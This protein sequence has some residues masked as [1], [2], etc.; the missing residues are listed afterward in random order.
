MAKV[1]K[2]IKGLL[3]NADK[4]NGCRACEVI[5]SAFHAN[6]RYGSIN[7]ARSRIRVVRDPLKDIY[8][9]VQAGEYT[10]SECTGR[11]RYIVDG[12]EYTRKQ[13]FDLV[14]REAGLSQPVALLVRHIRIVVN[15][16][17]RTEP[18]VLKTAIWNER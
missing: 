16:G 12:K 10:A 1:R 9:P 4:C 14:N 2:T 11:N 5:C 15:D 8:V 18:R 7:P 3:I 13:F 17:V 6:P